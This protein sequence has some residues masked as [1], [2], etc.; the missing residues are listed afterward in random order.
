MLEDCKL[1]KAHAQP[2][3]V[4]QLL[5]KQTNWCKPTIKT[6]GDLEPDVEDNTEDD[7]TF[8]KPLQPPPITV[9]NVQYTDNIHQMKKEPNTYHT[10]KP[11]S[12]KTYRTVLKGMHPFTNPE[13]IIKELRTRVV[14]V[15]NK[16]NGV[17]FTSSDENLF[18][19]FSVYCALALHYAKLNDK[20]HRT[21]L[22]N[23][24]NLNL[25]SLQL[26]PC[27]H[28]ISNF[29]KN[30]EV[31]IPSGFSEW[32]VSIDEEPIMPQMVYYMIRTVV[33]FQ[34]VNVHALK[35]FILTVRKCYRPNPYHNWEHAF[36]VAH[37]M[38]NILLR[39]KS[40]F[41]N[42][43][44]KA[45]IIACVCHDLDHGGYT[46]NFLQKTEQTLSQLYDESFLENHHFQV[47]MLIYKAF[48]F[49][50]IPTELW[51]Q[52]SAEMKHCI[53]ATDLANYFKVRIKLLQISNDQ[54][55][56]WGNRHHRQLCKAIMMTSC[57]LS[58]SCKPYMVAKTLTDNVI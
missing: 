50:D 13:Y 33:G 44:I 31:S 3:G 15:V 26:K 30:P 28:D 58:G 49:Y 34:E 54:G 17:V 51:Q 56:D 42:V 47:A 12:E 39:N 21:D 8:V 23:E 57:D 14:Q 6:F 2:R 18:K 37:C 16:M 7:L 27:V 48:P 41:T 35:E 25:L 38:Y 32:Y 9:Y 43:E 46:N 55:L 20:M 53:L 45:L 19:T 22:L 29:S 11:K 36:N 40:L 4:S 5:A 24:S 10:C 1:F 52:I